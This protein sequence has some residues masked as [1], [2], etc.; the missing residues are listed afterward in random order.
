VDEVHE[1]TERGDAGAPGEEQEAGRLQHTVRWPSSGVIRPRST[2]SDSP[3]VSFS[4][5]EP[6]CTA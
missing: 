1:D 5:P 2:A 6:A 4:A 3:S